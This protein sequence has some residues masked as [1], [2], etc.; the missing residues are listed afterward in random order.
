METTLI[1]RHTT[2]RAD[3]EAGW[4]DVHLPWTLDAWPWPRC[5]SPHYASVTQEASSWCESFQAFSPQ[6]QEA[7]NKCNF[8]YVPASNYYIGILTCGLPLDLLAS[9]VYSKLD[10]G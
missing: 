3:E 6:A 1:Q 4:I 7:F 2:T 9:L 8:S 5:E 10:K